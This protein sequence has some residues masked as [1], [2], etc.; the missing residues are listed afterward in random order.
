MTLLNDVDYAHLHTDPSLVIT[1]AEGRP[2]VVMPYRLG[3]AHPF[4]RRDGQTVARFPTSVQ[5]SPVGQLPNGTPVAMQQTL[6]K[7][8][9]PTTQQMRISSNGGMRPPALPVPIPATN[10]TTNP[11]SSPQPLPLPVPQPSPGGIN[12]SGRA[13]ISMPHVDVPKPDIITT[14][15]IPPAVVA[16]TQSQASQSADSTPSETLVSGTPPP[17]PKTANPTPT[18]QQHL[19]LGVP[20]NGFHLT[21]MTNISMGVQPQPQHSS[22]LSTQQFQNIKNAFANMPPSD[23][24]ALQNAQRLMSTPYGHG[25]SGNAQLSSAANVNLA[26]MQMQNR[27]AMQ[28]ITPPGRPAS[29][30]NG[31]DAQANGTP[32]ISSPVR[33]PSANGTRPAL[34]NGT[35]VNGI[36]GQHSILP[37]QQHTASPIPNISQSQ[38]PPRVAMTPALGLTSPSLVHTQHAVGTTQTGF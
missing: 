32:M 14:P 15:A 36:N 7:M 13:A 12:G 6:K 37:L 22:G 5:P 23:L 19:A 8:A 3:I 24:A 33:S 27:A 10:G 2:Q 31:V 25:G 29:V 34:R 17:R 11:V 16:I 26:K 28:W 38:S 9:P 18:P 30:V 1:N 4:L 20:T 21:P 35:H